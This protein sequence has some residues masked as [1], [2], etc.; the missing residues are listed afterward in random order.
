MCS[1]AKLPRCCPSGRRAEHPQQT[2]SHL[3]LVWDTRSS[4]QRDRSSGQHSPLSKNSPLSLLFPLFIYI[5][6]RVYIYIFLSYPGLEAGNPL[7]GVSYDPRP[8]ALVSLRTILRSV[9][10]RSV[11]FLLF[12]GYTS[13]PPSLPPTLISLSLSFSQSLLDPWGSRICKS[14]GTVVRRRTG[15]VRDVALLCYQES[16]ETQLERI[17]QL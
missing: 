3:L 4:T 15:A 12:L 10:F 8:R 11:P 13:R 14:Y 6:I 9:P 1:G 5:Y 16:R 7:E 2:L 17:C